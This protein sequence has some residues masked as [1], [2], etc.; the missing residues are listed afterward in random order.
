MDTKGDEKSNDN[1]LA[2]L[3]VILLMLFRQIIILLTFTC[4]NHVK[5]VLVNFLQP[6]FLY[7]WKETT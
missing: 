5:L 1:Q 3:Y 4:V 2:A 6:F 7:K